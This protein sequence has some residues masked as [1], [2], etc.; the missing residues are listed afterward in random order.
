MATTKNLPNNFSVCFG[1]DADQ[2]PS[3]FSCG[4]ND[5][6]ILYHLPSSVFSG[7]Q[8]S[9]RLPK[10]KNLGIFAASQELDRTVGQLESVEHH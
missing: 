2:K 1:K 6:F 10:T 3:E 9:F 5:S 8:K 7:T 4:T